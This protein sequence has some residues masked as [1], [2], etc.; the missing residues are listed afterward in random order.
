[1]CCE[2]FSYNNEVWFRLSDGTTERLAETHV[3][4]ISSTLEKIE[5][6]YPTA[7][8]ALCNEYARCKP[9]LPFFRYRIVSRFCKCNFGNIDDIPDIDSSGRF[10]FEYVSCPLRGECRYEHIICQPK[11]DHHISDAEMRVLR[12]WYYGRKKEDIADELYLSIHTVNNHIRNAFTRI[13]IHEKAEFIK[14]ADS[15]KLFK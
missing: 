5:K 11:F 3:E 10:H 9:N 6:F 1:M 15:N 7:Y 12:L 14:Y 13:G 8:N 2:F 4:V